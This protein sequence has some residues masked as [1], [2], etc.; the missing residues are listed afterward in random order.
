MFYCHIAYASLNQLSFIILTTSTYYTSNLKFVNAGLSVSRIKFPFSPPKKWFLY[1]EASFT[2]I[3]YL[4]VSPYLLE[5]IL[6]ERWEALR[7]SDPLFLTADQTQARENRR[8][9][10]I[11]D[12]NLNMIAKFGVITR[13]QKTGNGIGAY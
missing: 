2:Q 4:D 11:T 6:T 8:S 3:T 5:G 7:I 12:E 9:E 13:W 10:D 1:Y